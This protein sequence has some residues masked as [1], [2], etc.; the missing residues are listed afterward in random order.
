MKKMMIDMDDVICAGG[1]LYQLNKFLKTNYSEDDMTSYY[2]QELI[3]EENREEWNKYIAE[4]NI[5]KEGNVFFPDALKTIEKLSKKYE[6]YIV[7]AYV[8]REFANKSG[9]HLY[10]KF[11][12]LCENMPFLDPTHFIFCDHKEL[13]SCDIKI[14]DKLVN[15]MENADTKLLF[16][17]YHNRNISD[18]ELKSKG[19]IRVC[20]WRQIG[21][22]LLD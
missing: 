15:I 14:D 21:A 3:P 4:Q 2:M 12:C 16:D 20:T 13:I 8:F 1:F 9:N 18:E 5:Y 17:A 6:V 10:N 22:L 11:R 19:V 7:T